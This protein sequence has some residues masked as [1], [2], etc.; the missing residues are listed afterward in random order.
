MIKC[1]TILKVKIMTEFNADEIIKFI[2]ERTLKELNWNFGKDIP[3]EELERWDKEALRKCTKEVRKIERYLSLI[4][5]N[6]LVC[7]TCGISQGD[8]RCSGCKI[9]MNKKTKIGE[10]RNWEPKFSIEDFK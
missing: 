3:E 8:G 4:E 5:A 1:G 7:L 10:M 6:G 9:V 2:E